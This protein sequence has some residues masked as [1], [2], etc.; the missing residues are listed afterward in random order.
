M[1]VI[2]AGIMGADHARL[3]ASEVPGVK[4][5][6]ICDADET[7]ARAVADL[8]GANHV[9]T[10]PLSVIADKAI[11]AVLIAA[12]DRFHAELTLAAIAAGKPVLCEKPLSPEKKECLAILAAEEKAGKRLVQVGFMRRFDPSY[13]EV[14]SILNA[15][16]LGRAMM[17]HC[18]HR[19]VSAPSNF[20]GH[21]AISS[22]A[23]HEFDIARW[24]LDADFTSVTV[25]RPGGVK[26]VP[27]AALFMVLETAAGQLVNIEVN[28][29]AAYGYDVRGEV[30]GEK[31]T[32]SL[33]SPIN[34][35]TNAAL[36]NLTSY[37]ADWRPRFEE[38][39]R[40]Q[41]IAWVQSISSGKPAG[42]NAWD[43]Y[44]ATLTAE[45]GIQ[46]L[47]SKQTVAISAVPKPKFYAA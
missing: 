46:A 39:Y 30:V 9:S 3:L 26:A 5:E 16:T 28:N 36:Q 44:W 34:A 20:E 10:D 31:G 4:L 1:A 41:N 15:G 37:A 7:R 21:M 18:I 47:S 22:S 13:V 17:F 24:M 14:K 45:A 8:H 43:G 29:N 35:E 33:R 19:N 27:G 12:P 32:A 40:R 25:Y 38:A 11:D 42:A 23:P 6:V 2:G